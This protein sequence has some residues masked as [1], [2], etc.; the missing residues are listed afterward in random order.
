MN[1][2]Q[3]TARGECG[4]Q[5]WDRLD[6]WKIQAERIMVEA[7]ADQLAMTRGAANSSLP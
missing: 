6:L 7:S 5:I 1:V 4:K 3:A 2:I